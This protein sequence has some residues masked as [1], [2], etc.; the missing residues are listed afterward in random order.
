MMV[1]GCFALAAIGAGLISVDHLL[2]G[3]GGRSRSSKKS[4][5]E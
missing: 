2:F 1:V 4:R 5:Q 3:S